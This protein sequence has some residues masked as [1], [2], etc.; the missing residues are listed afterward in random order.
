[1]PSASLTIWQTERLARLQLVENQCAAALAAVPPTELLIEENLRGCVLH[2]SAHFQGFCRDLYTEAAETIVTRSRISLRPLIRRQFLAGM[3]LDR[4]NPTL[5]NIRQDF[6]R[7]GIQLNLTAFPG[8]TPR[9]AHLAALNTWRNIAAHHGTV[10]A[11]LP[12]TLELFRSWRES[13]AELARTLDECTYNILRR[14]LRRE[15]WVP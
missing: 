13:C 2:L 11:G 4:G 9:L 14:I 10:P 8:I 3:R 12:L 5:E 15:P 6:E 1:M 7:F